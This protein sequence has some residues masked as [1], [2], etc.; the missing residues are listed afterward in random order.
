MSDDKLAQMLRGIDKLYPHKTA[1]KYPRILE[2]ITILW[3]TVGMSRYFNE[4]LFD[5]RGDREGFPPEVMA[6]I[7]ALSNYHESTKPSRSALESAW[8]DG[9]ELDRLERFKKD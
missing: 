7:F 3:G 6:E 8:H 4:I 5:E 9:A 2:R 1:E